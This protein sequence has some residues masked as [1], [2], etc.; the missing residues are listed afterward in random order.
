MNSAADLMA[1]NPFSV[2]F[3]RPG[4]LAYRFADGG[5]PAALLQKFAENGRRGAIIGPHGTG[6]STL[7]AELLP[8][9]EARGA[10]RRHV[11]LHDGR[12]RLPAGFTDGATCDDV[13]VVDGYE[14]LAWPAR[15]KLQRAAR[16]SGAGLLVTA[17]RA[18]RRLPTLVTTR[19]TVQSTL[20][21]V[22]RLTSDLPSPAVSID[23]VRCAWER[24]GG[25]VREVFFALYDLYELRRV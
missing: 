8:R 9:L 11:A 6:K 10:R 20:A 17:H 7:L 22:T 25:D 12:R 5:S 18:V 2:R 4:A 19:S 21:L 15:W 23:D 14:Q 24:Y 3:T 1:E 16:S 13:L